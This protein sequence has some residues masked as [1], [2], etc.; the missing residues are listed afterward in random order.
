MPQRIALCQNRG[1][2]I[3]SI[4]ESGKPKAGHLENIPNRISTISWQNS[5]VNVLRAAS[6]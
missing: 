5:E 6:Q 1:K 4:R 3:I 2:R